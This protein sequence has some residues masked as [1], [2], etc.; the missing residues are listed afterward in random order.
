MTVVRSCNV[1]AYALN[2]EICH[3]ANFVGVGGA[4]GFRFDNLRFHQ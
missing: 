4:G 2:T 1:Y 3:D